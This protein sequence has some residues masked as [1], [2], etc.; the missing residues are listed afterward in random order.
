MMYCDLLVDFL[1]N[2]K[3]VLV[4]STLF[5]EIEAKAAQLANEIENNPNYKAR[6]DLENGDEE[7]RFAAVVRPGEGSSSPNTEG[8]Y[9]PPA[10]RKN[11]QSG[12]LSRPAQSPAPAQSP[13]ERERDRERDRDREDRRDREERRDDR[14]DRDRDR[15]DRRDG[16]DRR[17]GQDSAQQRPVNPQGP[18]S[19]QVVQGPQ[20]PVSS[21]PPMQQVQ[22]IP[23]VQQVPQTQ[24]PQVPQGPPGQGPK[25]Y[26]PYHHSPHFPPPTQVVTQYQQGSPTVVAYAQPLYHG[27]MPQRVDTVYPMTPSPQGGYPAQT[28]LPQREQLKVNGMEPRG[29]RPPISGRGGNHCT[30]F[31]LH[32]VFFS[33]YSLYEIVSLS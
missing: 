21:G 17:L 19:G 3:L 2:Y 1:H 22:T 31:A 7:E 26:P 5:R 33:V 15:A 4:L 13:Q 11:P 32:L 24:Q 30:C 8:K 28:A 20:P 23:Q 18:S 14:R 25:Q 12:K 16:D 27:Q 10:K 6:I 9:V 29:Q